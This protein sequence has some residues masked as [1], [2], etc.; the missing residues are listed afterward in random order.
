MLVEILETRDGTQEFDLY[1][2]PAHSVSVIRYRGGR[3]VTYIMGGRRGNSGHVGSDGVAEVEQT[4]SCYRWRM[5]TDEEEAR[6]KTNLYMLNI[7][8]DISNREPNISVTTTSRGTSAFLTA[9]H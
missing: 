9:A 8:F 4:K 2:R 1:V 3:A 7:A 5:S 6:Q